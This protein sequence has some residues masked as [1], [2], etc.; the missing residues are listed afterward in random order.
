MDEL[1]RGYGENGY[2]VGVSNCMSCGD[3]GFVY[4]IKQKCMIEDNETGEL[5]DASIVLYLC[6]ECTTFPAVLH[7]VMKNWT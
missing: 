1:L 5:K 3:F 6:T 7:F 2:M 4:I